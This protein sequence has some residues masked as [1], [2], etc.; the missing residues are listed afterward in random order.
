MRPSTRTKAFPDEGSSSTRI[1]C[2][3]LLTVTVQLWDMTI[4]YRVDECPFP[5]G[6]SST[7]LEPAGHGLDEAARR[8]AHVHEAQR[9]AQRLSRRS[10]AARLRGD[11]SQCH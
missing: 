2:S 1:S 5:E 4:E 9:S 7:R 10:V 8:V 6:S 11:H 3:R